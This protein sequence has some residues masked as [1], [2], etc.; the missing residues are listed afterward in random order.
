MHREEARLHVSR[1]RGQK[2]SRIHQ[3]RGEV[4]ERL[5]DLRVVGAQCLFAMAR[6]RLKSRSASA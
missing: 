4:V 1:A 3:A 5:A 6:L 2:S